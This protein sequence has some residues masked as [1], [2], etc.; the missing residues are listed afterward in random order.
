[1]SEP[2]L[3]QLIADYGI[4]DPAFGE[5]IQKLTLL[6]RPARVVRTSVPPFSTIA[7]GFW[8]AQYALVNPVPDMII[9]TN[10]APRQD[11]KES[12]DDNEG[13]HL[14][15]ALLKNGVKV[16]GVN[17]GFCF[18]FIKRDIKALHRVNVSNKG[19]Q[20]RS[21]DFYPEAVIGIAR[22]EEKFIGETLDVSVIPE[23]PSHRIAWVDG[24]GNMKTTI[25]ASEMKKYKSGQPFLVTIGSMKRTAWYSDGTFSVREGELAFAPGSS[26]GRDR[27]MELFL[28]GLSAWKE[29]GKPGT[30]EEF[31]IE[32]ME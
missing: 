4:S 23:V 19:S 13:E 8:T 30:E 7:T 6:Y 21:R 15:Y 9:Y 16:V 3:I 2:S 24:Y 14:I 5:V 29:M 11:N 25:R 12:R 32:A 18:S 26:G 17:A 10:T 20:F 31:S 27:F 1:M 28:R 22:G